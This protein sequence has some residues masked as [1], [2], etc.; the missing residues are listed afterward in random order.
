MYHANAYN[1]QMKK[2]D[3]FVFFSDKAYEKLK[4]YLLHQVESVKEI[5]ILVDHFTKKY[6]LPILFHHLSFLKKSNIIQIKPGEH[7]KNIDTCI[8][9]CNYLEK[10]KCT[11]KSLILNL[12]GGVITDI[13]GFIASIFKR[14]IRFINIP[15]TL[16]G[17]VDASIGYKTGINF[18][19]IKNEIGSFYSPEF[20]IIDISFLKTLS[21]KEIISGI[22]EMLKHGLIADKQFWM[23]LKENV[24]KNKIDGINIY[25]NKTEWNNLIYRSIIIKQKIVYNDPKEK[26]LRKILNFGHTIGHAIE[27]FF[28]SKK[29][30]KIL[31]GIAIAMGMIYESIISYKINGLSMDEYKEIKSVLSFLNYEK[32]EISHSEVDN[33]FSIMKHDKKNEKNQIQFSL[34]KKIGQCSYNCPVSYPLIK[35]IFG[36]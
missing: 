24:I 36:F 19:C 18:N 14:G 15:T 21:K 2:I 35:E 10:Y 17:M 16:L 32:K 20:L 13:G 28:L 30:Y 9:I 6:C 34:L 33:L 23:D 4:I 7:E 3:N 11:R 26:G 5:F 27:S 31:H 25:Q 29:E 22:F 12:G 8:Q 1:M